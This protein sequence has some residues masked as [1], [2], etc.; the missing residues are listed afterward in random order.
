MSRQ[1]LVTDDSRSK[2]SATYRDHG[3][4]GWE[5]RRVVPPFQ[6]PASVRFGKCQATTKC[7]VADSPGFSVNVRPIRPDEL[8]ARGERPPCRCARRR[9]RSRL[10]RRN[11]MLCGV[12][13]SRARPMVP[14]SG[15]LVEWLLGRRRYVA[16]RDAADADVPPSALARIDDLH[17]GRLPEPGPRI[18]RL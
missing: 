12:R 18:E 4:R 17:D 14:T 1:S 15:R 11:A 5:L 16:E 2:F 10:R 3:R 6:P 7:T 13:P 8:V 9:A